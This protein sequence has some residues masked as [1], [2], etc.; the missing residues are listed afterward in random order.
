MLISRAVASMR[1]ADQPLMLQEFKNLVLHPVYDGLHFERCG[2]P[3][4]YELRFVSSQT[5]PANG[6]QS[7]NTLLPGRIGEVGWCFTKHA[8]LFILSK[9]LRDSEVAVRYY[10]V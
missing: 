10:V 8:Q 5:M 7:V 2:I 9:S 3:L 1:W 4:N 6:L